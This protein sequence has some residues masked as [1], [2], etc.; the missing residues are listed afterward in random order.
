MITTNADVAI[1][2]GSV[3]PDNAPSNVKIAVENCDFHKYAGYGFNQLTWYDNFKKCLEPHLSKP[4]DSY[5]T[6]ELNNLIVGNNAIACKT[7]YSFIS[8]N[9]NSLWAIAELEKANFTPYGN[10]VSGN[11]VWYVQNHYLP[12]CV[13]LYKALQG[14]PI[15]EDAKKYAIDGLNLTRERIKSMQS[16]LMIVDL[17]ANYI[18]KAS[19][20]ADGA[21]GDATEKAFQISRL[22]IDELI[23]KSIKQ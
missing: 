3:Y 12:R 21:W 6:L 4:L 7:Y 1:W 18:L 23:K 5:T 10:L 2:N 17:N 22:S 19:G 13:N 11:W 16:F 20:G 9:R 15:N 8:Q 14:L